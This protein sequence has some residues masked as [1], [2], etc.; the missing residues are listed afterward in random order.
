VLEDDAGNLLFGI[1]NNAL[2]DFE[3]PGINA[4]RAGVAALQTAFSNIGVSVVTRPGYA[5]AFEDDQQN[6]IFGV[7]SDTLEIISPTIARLEGL[8]ASGGAGTSM[9]VDPMV[10]ERG[11]ARVGET[12]YMYKEGIILQPALDYVWNQTFANEMACPITPTTT[13]T[14]QVKLQA[15][16]ETNAVVTLAD[17]PVLVTGTPVS[18]SVPQNIIVL[19]DS[20]VAN[21]NAGVEGPFVNELSRRLTGIG[22]PIL[23]GI[24]SP[25]ALS[26]TNI[27]FRG[28]L[29]PGPVKHEGRAGWDATKYLYTAATGT[30]GEEA[31]GKSNAFWNPATSQFD[32]QYYMTQSGFRDVDTTSGVVSDGS[33][34]TMIVALGW[35]D[36]YNQTPESSAAEMGL[37]IDR[38]HAGYPAAR[39]IVLGLNPAPNYKLY[40][41]SRM[42]SQRAIWETV[43]KPFGK[44]YRAA[45]ST[46]PN[47]EFL[48]ISHLIDGNIAYN[49]PLTFRTSS[50][51][52]TT[53]TAP[54]DYVHQNEVG[55]G[56]YADALFMCLLYHLCRGV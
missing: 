38:I 29:G 43:V 37:L 42:V 56:M 22:S 13:A 8:I 27:Y 18:P 54:Y 5:I 33:N 35:N 44:A 17:F 55:S 23:T 7:R 36:A 21:V 10:P 1:K 34:L 49:A 47:T 4:M 2:F 50:R 20:K 6:L 9:V 28:T 51:S 16:D 3:N 53:Y 46:R 32:L 19:G 41:G 11:Y 24:Q 39:V 31:D 12:T 26:L 48:Q 15:F 52:A 40:S 25:P 14:I 30:G 45:C